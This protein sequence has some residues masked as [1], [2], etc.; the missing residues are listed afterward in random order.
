[1][2]LIA[3]VTSTERRRGLAFSTCAHCHSGGLAGAV[4]CENGECPVLYSRLSST[5][6]LQALEQSMER[7]LNEW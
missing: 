5:S 3:E 7:L 4:A 1:M 6:R 2:G